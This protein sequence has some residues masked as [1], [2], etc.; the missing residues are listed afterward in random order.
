[1]KTLI[2]ISALALVSCDCGTLNT[3]Q[4]TYRVQKCNDAELDY[5]IIYN[6][7]NKATDVQCYKPGHN[8][9]DKPKDTTWEYTK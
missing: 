5:D 2:L 3:N 1:M 7:K 8:P 4:L 6:D 9:K